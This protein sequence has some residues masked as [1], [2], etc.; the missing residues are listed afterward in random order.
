LVLGNVRGGGVLQSLELFGV[1]L[2]FASLASEANRAADGEETVDAGARE[3]AIEAVASAMQ[4]TPDGA[5]PILGEQ[6]GSDGDAVNSADPPA[7]INLPSVGA[8]AGAGAF[9]GNYSSDLG[10]TYQIRANGPYVEITETSR[11]LFVPF[12]S[13]TCQGQAN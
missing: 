4:A 12:T 5:A 1:R 9:A 3:A 7:A 8:E 11:L 13:M 2:Q 6:V 10:A